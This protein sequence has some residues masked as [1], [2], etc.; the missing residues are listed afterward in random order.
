VAVIGWIE[1]IPDTQSKTGRS[2]H[3]IARPAAKRPRKFRPASEN[4]AESC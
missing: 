1:R 2:H 4:R 3:P